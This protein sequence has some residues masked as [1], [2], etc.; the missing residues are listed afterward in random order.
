MNVSKAE[1]LSLP[2]QLAARIVSVSGRDVRK[3]LLCLE[4]CRVQQFP[5]TEAQQPRLTDW[6]MYITVWSDHWP[7]S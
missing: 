7:L 5:F 2:E 3:A 1:D 4:T 6:E